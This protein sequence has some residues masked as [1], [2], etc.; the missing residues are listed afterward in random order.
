MGHLENVYTT[1]VNSIE[2]LKG[3]IKR[4]RRRIRPSV[5]RKVWDD[6]KLSL[7]ILENHVV[8]T[9]IIWY[10]NKILMGLVFHW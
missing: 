3:R 1:S 10:S 8:D 2:D 4:E 5:L 7:N 6:V 9:L